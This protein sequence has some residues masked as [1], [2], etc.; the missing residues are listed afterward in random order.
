VDHVLGEVPHASPLPDHYREAQDRDVARAAATAAREK[1]RLLLSLAGEAG[2]L[3]G[4]GAGRSI[5][6]GLLG[7]NRGRR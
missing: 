3:F 4:G 6:R 7:G 1:Q 5:A 2:N